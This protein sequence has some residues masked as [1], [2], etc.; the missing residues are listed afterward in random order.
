MQDGTRQAGAAG[1]AATGAAASLGAAAA[2]ACCVGPV[3]APVIVGVL[4]ASG[5]AWA[6]SL[7]PYSFHILAAALI[8]LAGGFWMTYRGRARAP[9]DG[10]APCR[11]RPPLWLRAV[12]WSSAMLW[13]LSVGLNLVLPT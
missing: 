2:T 11:P 10:A 13:L 5:A 3:A 9:A 12:L 6:A 7:R 8:P 1:A 4:G